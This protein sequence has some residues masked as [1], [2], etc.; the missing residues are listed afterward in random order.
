MCVLESILDKSI[1]E[2]LEKK[3]SFE[4]RVEREKE[5]NCEKYCRKVFWEE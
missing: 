5:F 2:G 1:R 3:K 4:K